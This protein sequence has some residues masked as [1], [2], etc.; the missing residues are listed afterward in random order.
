[1]EVIVLIDAIIGNLVGDYLLQNDWMALNK[2]RSSFHCAVHCAIWTAC[3]IL[4]S[5]WALWTAVPLFVT[6]FIQDRTNV[7]GIY[8]DS[9]GQKAFKTGACAPWSSIIVDNVFH[10]VT[11]WA[12]SKII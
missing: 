9:V 1:V 6:H 11:I 2:K 7:I 8:M 12:I 10:I 5:Q 3:V 4:F